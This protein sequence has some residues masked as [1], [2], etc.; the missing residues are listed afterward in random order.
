MNFVQ[1]FES[2]LQDFIT[3]YHGGKG[4]KTARK[5]L[6]KTLRDKK[7]K[8]DIAKVKTTWKAVDENYIR[9]C[10]KYPHL[11]IASRIEWDRR[12]TDEYKAKYAKVRS[13]IDRRR[14]EMGLNL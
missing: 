4:Y 7:V 14:K 6:Q 11:D 3:R 12:L 13:F 5:D 1:I 8:R 10:Q 2:A 9:I